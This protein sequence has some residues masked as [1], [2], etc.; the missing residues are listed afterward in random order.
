MGSHPIVSAAS[1]QHGLPPCATR[2]AACPYFR[3]TTSCKFC[4]LIFVTL[5]SVRVSLRRMAA[6]FRHSRKLLRRNRLAARAAL[7]VQK[8]H[9][10]LERAGVCGVPQE[11]A[12]PPDAHQ[13]FVFQFFQMVRKRRRGNPQLLLNFVYH[14]PLRMRCQEYSQDAQPRLRAN[15]RKHIGK[16]G[17]P[18]RGR[19]AQHVSIILVIWRLS[20]F[21]FAPFFRNA[22][23]RRRI[24]LSWLFS[25]RKSGRV[26][27]LTPGSPL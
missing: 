26:F 15:R 16:A 24:L 27:L 12:F 3:L 14:Q 21:L 17:E 19:V 11:L 1:P 7:F 25:P 4:S 6:S 8:A 18:F 2:C 13:S 9:Q 23:L 10:F 22:F 5:P 20:S